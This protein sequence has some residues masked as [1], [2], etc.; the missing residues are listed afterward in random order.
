[1]YLLILLPFAARAQSCIYTDLSK[2]F[3]YQIKVNRIKPKGEVFSDAK[4]RLDIYSKRNNQLIQSIVFDASFLF[5]EA[6]AK[7]NTVRSY[8]TGYH[9]HAEEIDYDFGD[10]IIADLNADGLE[11]IA[12]K[13]D[14]GGNGGPEYNFYLQT[15]LHRFE[16]DHFL[17]DSVGSF[18]RYINPEKRTITTQIHANAYQE[19]KKTF[20]YNPATRKWKLI[21]WVMVK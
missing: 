15:K 4:I 14:S 21:S 9:Q 11:D 2:T 16:Q 8:I 12:I 1:M 17:T 19:S 6:Y 3:N 18:P 20:R 5:D 13:Q 7:C 10:L